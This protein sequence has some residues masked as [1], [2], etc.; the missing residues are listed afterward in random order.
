[1]DASH[2]GPYYNTAND[3]ISVC[4]AFKE[5]VLESSSIPDTC[6]ALKGHLDA[7]KLSC[8]LGLICM[9]SL[10]CTNTDRSVNF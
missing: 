10:M 1:M 3:P 8:L 4:I 5:A 2:R 9:L 7:Q 6:I